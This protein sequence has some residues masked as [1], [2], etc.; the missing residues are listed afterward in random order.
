MIFSGSLSRNLG[1]GERYFYGDQFIRTA[2]NNMPL[3]NVY[4]EKTAVQPVYVT[5]PTYEGDYIY[6][7]D[8]EMTPEV[9]FRPEREYHSPERSSYQW[10]RQSRS[11]PPS[12]PKS[13]HIPSTS[14]R[15]STSKSVRQVSKSHS[16]NT[17]TMNV[18]A[19][20][21]K[22]HRPYLDPQ[23]QKEI[24][25][26]QGKQTPNINSSPGP[27]IKGFKMM[28]NQTTTRLSERFT[29][30]KPPLS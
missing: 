9:N 6:I 16:S 7:D 20:R 13:L 3:Y 5:Q 19:E 22:P 14:K 17:V 4:P 18:T 15:S 27:G 12:P 24:A 2:S 1:Q 23:V 21:P 8:R 11:P 30:E 29:Q 28:P 10:V 25:L 26:L